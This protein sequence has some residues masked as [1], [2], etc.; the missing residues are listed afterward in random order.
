MALCLRMVNTMANDS[1]FTLG[2]SRAELIYTAQV[3]G[4][5][6]KQAKKSSTE[7]LERFIRKQGEPPKPPRE[8][9]LG[10]NRKQLQEGAKILGMSDK[11]A[12]KASQARLEEFITRQLGGKGT[13][14]PAFNDR[15]LRDVRKSA[16]EYGVADAIEL[17]HSRIKKLTGK[18]DDN[19][20]LRLTIRRTFQAFVD[21]PVTNED[22]DHLIGEM[23]HLD[24]YA[25]IS[26]IYN[27]DTYI[28]DIYNQYADE[29]EEEKQ[30]E[31]ETEEFTTNNSNGRNT[32]IKK[33]R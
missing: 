10:L 3:Y 12:N 20:Y 11:N 2:L 16:K 19:N 8:Q 1:R 33:K 32:A 5:S 4:K 14:V 30:Q 31:E 29:L 28:V 26:G 25:Q 9:R 7:R 23:E 13:E 15:Q 18:S 17:T 27:M 24:Y 21:R 6:E 22:I